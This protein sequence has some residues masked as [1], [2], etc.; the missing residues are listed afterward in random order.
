MTRGKRIRSGAW[1]GLRSLAGT[2]MILDPAAGQ[3]QRGPKPP[4]DL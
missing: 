4:T 1:G 3:V 2:E